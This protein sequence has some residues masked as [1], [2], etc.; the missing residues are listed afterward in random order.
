MRVR[1]NLQLKDALI[2]INMFQN[3]QMESIDA[4][5]IPKNAVEVHDMVFILIS[6]PRV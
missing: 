5:M 3:V 6:A 4:V 2:I 1:Q